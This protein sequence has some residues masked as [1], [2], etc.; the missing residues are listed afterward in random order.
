MP[1]AKPETRGAKPLP[2]AKKVGLEIDPDSLETRH[3][4]LVEVAKA[5][6]KI[7]ALASNIGYVGALDTDSLW[8]SVEF[9][10]RRSV[11][12]ILA[13]GRGLLLIKEQTPHGEFEQQCEQ[14]GIHPRAARRLMG[15]A[16]KFTKTDTM[17]VLKAAGSQAKVLE[18][19]LLED[20]ELEA[21]EAGDT[22]AGITLDDVERMSASQLRATIREAR[23]D[24]AAKDERNQKLTEA[25][26][27]A[28]EAESKAKRLWKSSTPDQR[29]A[30]L[31]QKVLAAK[32]AVIA[33]IGHEGGGL[34]QA[35][36]E[37]AAHSEESTIDCSVFMGNVLG[38]LLT[39]IRVVRD[40]YEYGF[41]IP[42]VAD[43]GA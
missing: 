28:K 41:A 14:R 9:R 37:L 2:P 6:A 35:F 19:T 23:A 30:A 34:V 20:E 16:L 38:E 40:E 24:I 11:E 22:A 1:A 3:G 5:E 12:D 33:D 25:V 18:L 39:A 43:G 10:Q 7:Q 4:E 29:Q 36:I 13:M 21:L 17:S 8:T 26:E 32:I 42:A 31:E 27:R 15:V